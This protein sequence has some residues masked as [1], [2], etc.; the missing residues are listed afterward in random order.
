M[1]PRSIGGTAL[2]LLSPGSGFSIGDKW[3][4]LHLVANGP[5][6]YQASGVFIRLLRRM[7]EEQVVSHRN[8][9]AHHLDPARQGCISP[10]DAVT[11][12]VYWNKQ[13]RRYPTVG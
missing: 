3:H 13:A 12:Q 5:P 4:S 9:L 2:H 7:A 6:G 8:H 11:Q 1:V 10:C